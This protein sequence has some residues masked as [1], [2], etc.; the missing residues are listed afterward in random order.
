[1]LNVACLNVAYRCGAWVVQCVVWYNGMPREMSALPPSP[2]P[3]GGL[4]HSQPRDEMNHSFIEVCGGRGESCGTR[5]IHRATSP[6]Q[7][8]AQRGIGGNLGTTDPGLVCAS[9]PLIRL[10]LASSLFISTV[11]RCI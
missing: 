2:G 7:H 8:T 6:H 11:E 9:L 4:V 10:N 5:A 3:A 1:M